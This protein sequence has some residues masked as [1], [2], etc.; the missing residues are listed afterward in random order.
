MAKQKEFVNESGDKL[1]LAPKFVYE[2]QVFKHLP[3]MFHLDDTKYFTTNEWVI[4]KISYVR[5]KDDHY[6]RHTTLVG[7]PLSWLKEHKYTEKCPEN[8]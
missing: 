8:K 6:T 7:A 1:I 5:G 3:N 2:V 4:D